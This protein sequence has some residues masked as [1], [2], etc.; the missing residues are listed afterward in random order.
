MSNHYYLRIEGVNLYAVLS[1]TSQISIIRGGSLLLREAIKIISKHFSQLEP[2]SSGASVGLFEFDAETEQAATELRQAVAERL[3]FHSLLQHLTF[4]VDIQAAG[5]HFLID[6]EAVLARNR[7]SQMRQLTIAMPYHNQNPKIGPCAIDNLRPA[8][9]PQEVRLQDEKKWVSQSVYKRLLYGRQQKRQFYRAETGLKLPFTQDLSELAEL[10]TDKF[11]NLNNKIAVLYFD[12]NGFSGIQ[13]RHCQTVDAMR[14]FDNAIQSK[15][16]AFL[17]AL[18][19]EI[20]TD[21]LFLTADNKIRLETLLWGGDE[22]IFVVPAWCGLTLLNFFYQASQDWSFAGEALTHAGGIVFCQVGTPIQ[23]VKKLAQDLAD[24][25]KDSP[26]GRKQNLFEYAVLESI[27]YPTE[28]LE[29]LRRQQFGD[30][31]SSRQPMRPFNH[32]ALA[33]VERLKKRC[34]KVKLMP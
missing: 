19:T 26:Q 9:A 11:N 10:K 14:C 1:D 23:R 31:A 7:F 20:K 32:T 18:L 5:E 34:L 29:M 4:V 22:M 8:S 28:S 27:D 2:I 13:A 33:T 17:K 6:K 25:V 3:N 15:R 12:G 16:K 24:A 21:P 30:L